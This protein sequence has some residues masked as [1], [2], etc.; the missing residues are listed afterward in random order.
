LAKIVDVFG[1]DILLPDGTL[2]RKKLG[3]IIFVDEKKRKKLNAIVHPAVKRAMFWKVIRCW[4]SGESCCVLDVPL[5]VEGGLWRLVGKVVVVYWYVHALLS[6]C[7]AVHFSEH[8][9]YSPPEVQLQRLMQRDNSTREDASARLSSQ[10]PITE[11]VIYADVVID[12]SGS[13]QE[14]ET[15][16][17]NFVEGTKKSVRGWWLIE[18]LFPPFAVVSA[19]AL[20]GWRLIWSLSRQKARRRQNKMK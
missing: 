9:T 7:E 5:L 16:V 17:S 3:G 10:L 2:D 4:I 13:L 8:C 18:W 14:L 15:Q 6:G 11:K 12:N 20:M 19:A 1:K